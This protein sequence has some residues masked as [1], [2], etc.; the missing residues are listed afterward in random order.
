MILKG[1]KHEFYIVKHV[2]YIFTM[3][4]DVFGGVNVLLHDG[5]LHKVNLLRARIAPKLS[6]LIHQTCVRKLFDTF[7]GGNSHFWHFVEN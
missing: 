3:A 4:L 7:C 2:I 1:I 5:L 6:I